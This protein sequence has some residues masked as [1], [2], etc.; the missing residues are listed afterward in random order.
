MSDNRR[1]YRAIREALNRFYGQTPE[2]NLARHLNT[3][4]A[5]IHGIVRSKHTH[6]PEMAKHIPSSTQLESRAKKLTRFVQ[7]ERIDLETYFAP[8]VRALLASLSHS[9][10]VLA[11]DGSDIGR[12][13]A[14]LMLN[15][16][17]RNRALPIGFLVRQGNKGHFSEALHQALLDQV[18]PLLPQ[19]VDVIL[20][21]DGEFDGVDLQA[22]A[23]RY[24][25]AYVVRTAKN[26]ILKQTHSG[27]FTC[28]DVKPSYGSYRFASAYFTRASYGPVQVVGWWAE[29]E[30]EPIYLVTNLTD[31]PQALAYYRKRFAIETFFSD[32]KSRGF[33]LHKSHLSDP[34][35]L[36]RL[37]MAACLA[38]LWIIYLGALAVDHGW[39]PYLHRADRCD[40]S[41]FQLGLRMLAHLLNEELPIPVAFYKERE[42]LPHEGQE[43]AY[44]KAA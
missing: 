1:Q 19:D 38:Y 13:C 35:R 42:E 4:A 20:V 30:K 41:L 27:E 16:V 15:V 9:P 39:V 2:G 34:T 14:A 23:Q 5:L 24:G 6:L 33:Q 37:L 26:T 28:E 43:L 32:Q 12:N 8:Y 11:I 40:L 21:G 29:G 22:Q 7:N 31:I 17:Y 44:P 10:L 36:A 3:L 25:W 18:Q